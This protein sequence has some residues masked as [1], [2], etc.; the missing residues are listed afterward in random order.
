MRRSGLSYANKLIIYTLL[1]G[2]LPV[3][4]LGSYSYYQSTKA[5]ER[6]T[7][8]GNAQLL[9]QT[10]MRVEQILTIAD[11]S[12]TYFLISPL[13]RESM[14]EPMTPERFRSA[15]DLME[16]VHKLQAFGS[17][18]RE[19]SLVNWLHGWVIK[20]DGIFQLSELRPEEAAVLEARADGQAGSCCWHSI[21][22][23]PGGDPTQTE[24]GAPAYLFRLEKTFPLLSPEPAGK[25]MADISSGLL[26][27][28]ISAQRTGVV[29]LVI[30]D[31][32]FQ[33]VALS[34]PTNLYVA[35]LNAVAKR[36][37]T[38][39]EVE[40]SFVSQA[41]KERVQVHFLKSDY[42]GWYYTA[43]VPL[44]EMRKESLLIG[45]FTVILS[46]M[47]LLLILMWSIFGSRRLSRPIRKLYETAVKL[48]DMK[49]TAQEDEISG[50]G[51]RLATLTK[52]RLQMQSQLE[53]HARRLKE[54]FALKIIQGTLLAR[55]IDEQLSL[56]GYGNRWRHVC[57][58]ALDIDTLEHTRYEERD[59][60]LLLYAAGNMIEEMIPARNRLIPVIAQQVQATVYGVEEPD[61]DGFK[62]QIY[63]LCASIQQTVGEMLHLQVSIGISRPYD[64]LVK[65]DGA[66][67]EAVEALKY[68]VRMGGESI[69]FI[70]DVHPARV[71]KSPYPEVLAL[72]LIE[73]CQSGDSVRAGEL[74]HRFLIELSAKNISSEE[75][76]VSLGRLLGD[77][78]RFAH[79]IGG[80][81][82]I[83][84]DAQGELYGQ[85]FAMKTVD[86]IETWLS[87]RVI[88]PVMAY[89]E[90]ME[91]GRLHDICAEMLRI[92][93]E[94][95]ESDLTLVQIGKMLNY[96]PG[97]LKKVFRMETG[98]SFSEYLAQHR[99]R[100]AKQLLTG[101]NLKISDI[102]ER[103]KYNNA[104]NFIRYFRR[105]EGMTPGQYR[106]LHH[107]G[108]D[109]QDGENAGE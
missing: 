109:R 49:Q 82:S 18:L 76:Q 14:H 101:T 61:K 16:G 75:Y 37:T 95:Y 66:F 6:R 100:I 98:M 64:S 40:G 12:L 65:A 28:M 105:W 80:A 42:T 67:Q 51:L 89:H 79:S 54:L 56:Y 63:D 74:L 53:H 13:M 97:Y 73:A 22:V 32:D 86:E 31:R 96:H 104:Q 26:A 7:E 87:E 103:L 38:E 99:L 71:E 23:D 91:G 3:V 29:D 1:I 30:L 50:I 78:L 25:I 24:G 69:L 9:Y 94:Q 21:P 68:R 17:G 48:S 45:V 72:H 77:L 43:L 5:V 34:H 4:V 2:I 47:L 41:G 19:V 102:A 59:R 10:M 81:D 27:D 55:E 36:L 90:R 108:Q 88:E 60:D 84:K 46:A 20:D 58:F 85:L 57:V 33:A 44:G 52:D 62:N 92:I 83:L 107:D 8:Q 15:A 11:H 35:D 106:E 93:H 39:T 70:S